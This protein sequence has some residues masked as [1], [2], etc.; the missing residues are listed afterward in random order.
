[1]LTD[2]K[3]DK[4][5]DERFSPPPDIKRLKNGA[6][7]LNFY[8]ERAHEAR[9]ATVRDSLRST[10]TTLGERINALAISRWFHFGRRHSASS[11]L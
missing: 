8:L 7:D 9:A 4:F 5:V 1:M 10:R 2:D 11:I 6:I 3:F